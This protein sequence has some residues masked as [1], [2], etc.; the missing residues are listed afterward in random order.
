MPA[1]LV[2]GL[3]VFGEFVTVS[4][5]V[6]VMEVGVMKVVVMEVGFMKVVVMEM[7][8]LEMV[9]I[10]MVGASLFKFSQT[11]LQSCHFD[12]QVHK[13]CEQQ[14]VREDGDADG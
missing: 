12:Q 4:M 8:V 9:V 11:L 10:E 3:V 7:V 1:C 13:G 2:A 6:V 5:T 14:K